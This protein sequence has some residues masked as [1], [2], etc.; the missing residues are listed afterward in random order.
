MPTPK[1]GYYI[2][3]KRV[4]SVTT[5]LKAGAFL[6]SD[7]LCW[8]SSG[9]AIDRIF[10][11]LASEAPSD[12]AGNPLALTFAGVL[13]DEG[14]RESLKKDAKSQWYRT[15]DR[16]G[17]VGSALH[18]AIEGFPNE[19]EYDEEWSSAEWARIF[20]GF[21]NHGDWVARRKP[22]IVAQEVQLL[23][24]ELRSGGT[25][26]LVVKVGEHTFLTDHKSSRSVSSSVVPQLG[27]YAFMLE[28]QM[29]I[30][31]DGAIVFHHPAP[32]DER[33]TP[34]MRVLPLTRAQLDVGVETFRACRIL[35]D[36]IPQC[37]KAVG[38]GDEL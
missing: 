24:R 35:Y 13:A 2:D 4:P 32:E 30:R 29:N 8:W 15:R 14:F 37:A 33:T 20:H 31:V 21:K 26:D 5:I 27:A 18:D 28:E 38:K 23:S 25:P 9:L 36:L 19:P 12:D 3:G 17:K 6:P 22:R 34:E 1:R 11:R 16:A 10:E 7:V